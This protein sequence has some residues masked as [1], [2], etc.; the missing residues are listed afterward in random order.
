MQINRYKENNNHSRLLVI[1]TLL[2]LFTP[3]FSALAADPDSIAA[4]R[5]MGK[6]FSSIA[7]KASPA[8][9]GLKAEKV[10]TQDS[11]TYQ[12]SPFGDDFYEYFFGPRSHNGLKQHLDRAL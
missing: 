3:P 2:L 8:V 6:A 4:L 12:N 7:E 9:V 11:R 1:S 5:Q 10:V